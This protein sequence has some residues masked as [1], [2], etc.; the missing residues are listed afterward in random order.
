M[1]ATYYKLQ[2]FVKAFGG[3]ETFCGMKKLLQNLK[4]V[5]ITFFIFVGMKIFETVCVKLFTSVKLLLR[6]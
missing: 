2:C 6:K 5:T 4:M 3:K 1:A